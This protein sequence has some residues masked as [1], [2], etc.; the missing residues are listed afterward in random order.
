MADEKEEEG[1]AIMT[2]SADDE[3]KR[4][5][6]DADTNASPGDENSVS[7]KKEVRWS[8]K[9]EVKEDERKREDIEDLASPSSNNVARLPA[10]DLLS[11]SSLPVE[12][13]AR[14]LLE[15]DWELTWPIWH[16]LPWQERKELAAQ[17]GYQT[18]GAFE[19][20]MSLQ[21]A[22]GGETFDNND[23]NN[24]LSSK[25]G[26]RDAK[27]NLKTNREKEEKK[28]A[29]VDQKED[30]EED[31]SDS[32][33]EDETNPSRSD[34][35]SNNEVDPD[36]DSP[37]L[38]FPDD[39]LQNIFSFLP[40]TLYGTKLA[41][42]SN[43]PHWTRLVR[44]EAALKGVCERVYLQQAKKK[45]LRVAKF[46][47][48]YRFMLYQRPRVQAGGGVYVLRYSRVKPI[49]RDMFTVSKQCS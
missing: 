16:M 11:Q 31:D 32:E 3:T 17:H 37:L 21:K 38:T 20:Y 34:T 28:P 13:S 29:A 2:K 48:S 25:Y 12:Q 45:L 23:N 33:T 46:H 36:T 43:H 47:H 40:A 27:Q 9:V 4:E 42:V 35:E 44:S 15:N 19:E 10:A 26:K 1:K 30:G 5:D 18:I 41:Y 7:H 22:L 6:E 8:G 49:Q 39:I 24:T 14:V